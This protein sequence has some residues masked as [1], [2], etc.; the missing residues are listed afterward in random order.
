MK[1]KLFEEYNQETYWE[2][3]DREYSSFMYGTDYYDENKSE[4]FAKENWKLFTEQE[5]NMINQVCRFRKRV[6][7]SS[8]LSR[9]YFC[10]ELNNIEITITKLDDE[11]FYIVVVGKVSRGL[12]GW[13]IYKCDQLDGVVD[14]LE[15][16]K[17]KYHK[18]KKD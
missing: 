17:K 12:V 1:I 7:T 10:D 11:W 4:E 14:C 18:Q 8:Y 16:L 5:I 6:I 13:K 2:I 9:Q 3:T 15:M